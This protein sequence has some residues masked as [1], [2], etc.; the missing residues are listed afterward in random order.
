MSSL[1]DFNSIVNT[2][3][4]LTGSPQPTNRAATY[5]ANEAQARMTNL[6]LKPEYTLFVVCQDKGVY[7]AAALP[8]EFRWGATSEYERP[9]ADALSSKVGFLGG[10]PRVVGLAPLVQALTARFW[11]GSA[12]TSISIPI[13]LQAQTNEVSDVLK[14]LADLLMLAMPSAPNGI[15]SILRSPGPHLD[16]TKASTMASQALKG[17]LGSTETAGNKTQ[18]L[19][20]KATSGFNGLKDGLKAAVEAASKGKFG[21]IVNGIEKESTAAFN[22]L[23]SSINNKVSIQI[24]QYMRFDN[25]VIQNVTQTHFVQPVGSLYGSSTGNMQRIEVE[26]EF[27]PF[28]D[29]TIENLTSIFLDSQLQQ[30]VASQLKKQKGG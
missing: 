23:D 1:F 15:G 16:L 8:P 21:D 6:G 11:S 14:P 28:F 27:E 12:T 2:V 7:V 24:G 17:F 22:S 25:V 30:Y 19:W 18:S 4:T 5:P 29:L 9:F 26:L 3:A 13:T 10:V 20:D